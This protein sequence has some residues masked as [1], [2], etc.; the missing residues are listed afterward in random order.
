[1]AKTADGRALVEG[2]WVRLFSEAMARQAYTYGYGMLKFAKTRGQWA[3][4]NPVSP[5]TEI[6]TPGNIWGHLDH[7]I[8]EGVFTGGLSPNEDV[9]YSICWADMWSD[10]DGATCKPIVFCFD[11][12]PVGTDPDYT[13]YIAIQCSDFNSDTFDY[14]GGATDAGLGSGSSWLKVLITTT[15]DSNLGSY[16]SNFLQANNLDK[17]IA[18][19]T[20][21]A[22]LMGRTQ[23]RN[24]NIDGD[25]TIVN[26]I[27][28]TFKNYYLTDW[29]SNPDQDTNENTIQT[30]VPVW[31][32]LATGQ[33]SPDGT[34]G[35]MGFDDLLDWKIINRAWKENYYRDTPGVTINP[36]RLPDGQLQAEFP[37]RDGQLITQFREI[38]IGPEFWDDS[39]AEYL[40]DALS[41]ADPTKQ[42]YLRTALENALNTGA[43][44]IQDAHDT[45]CYRG[46]VPGSNR[47]WRYYPITAGNAGIRNH[48]FP[49]RAA[50]QAEGG[51]LFNTEDEAIYIEAH[52][53]TDG[54]PLLAQPPSAWTTTFNPI[55][56]EPWVSVQFFW[57]LTLYD[58]KT[59][60]FTQNVGDRGGVHHAIR[61][62]DY[63][64]SPPG[65]SIGPLHVDADGSITV[66]ISDN[67]P[68]DENAAANW[69]PTPRD[70]NT[71]QPTEFKLIWRFYGPEFDDLINHTWEPPALEKASIP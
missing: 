55:A 9:V 31:N 63:V 21:W 56:M 43:E 69:L 20:R 8:N 30:A 4:E 7:T 65:S 6:Y 47:S 11:R 46:E 2:E 60:N 33:T 70:I 54:D 18:C 35:D 42:T 53:D 24:P 3:H 48:D 39:N 68:A 71:G 15:D 66:Y 50:I 1:M 49:V 12:D 40:S 36:G 45:Q 32:A 14:I 22:L 59:R 51:L 13:R 10:G 37:G 19:P 67:R 58:T 27:Q 34:D 28:A 41:Q 64:A 62:V 61:K 57:S 44:Y 52:K 29:Q 16:D 25:D 17:V 26:S 5:D 38:G 23:A